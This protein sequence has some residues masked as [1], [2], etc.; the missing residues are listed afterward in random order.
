MREVFEDFRRFSLV[1]EAD[2]ANMFAA[3]LTPSLKP[4][5][6]TTPLMMWAGDEA[7]LAKT[8]GAHVA[9]Y[10]ACGLVPETPPIATPDE[11]RKQITTLLLD[12]SPAVLLDNLTKVDAGPLASML[13]SGLWRDRGLGGNGNLVLP[14]ENVWFGTGFSLRLSDEITRRT[15]PIFLEPKDGIKATNREREEFRHPDLMAWMCGNRRVMLEAVL[16]IINHYLDGADDAA[17]FDWHTHTGPSLANYTRWVEVVGG[18]LASVGIEGFLTNRDRLGSIS[19]DVDELQQVAVFL[20]EWS[21]LDLE[22]VELQQLSDLAAYGGPLHAFLPEDAASTDE[23]VRKPG[24]AKLLK[25]HRGKSMI[26]SGLRLENDGGEGQHAGLR[27]WHVVSADV[28]N[29]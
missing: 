24:L 13:T 27:H 17:G 18:C 4:Y 6:G 11:Y 16:S 25:K 8:L 20:Y 3:M 29:A 21:K 14:V 7:G 23:T 12:G 28:R 15:V 1:N 9:L 19:E 26:G 10:P 2:L 22:P 5:V